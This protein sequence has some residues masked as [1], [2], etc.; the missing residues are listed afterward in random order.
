[1]A[2]VPTSAG[3]QITFNLAAAADV[4]ATITNVAGRPVRV[5]AQDRPLQAGLQ[6]LLWDRRADSGLAAPA[7]IYLIRVVARSPEGGQ[8]SALASLSVR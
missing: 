5:L 1:L 8:S 2:A 3:A 4:T 6:T 7:G